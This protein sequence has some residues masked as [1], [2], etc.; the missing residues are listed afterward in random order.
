MVSLMRVSRQRVGTLD[1]K[2]AGN[3]DKKREGCAKTT[4]TYPTNVQRDKKIVRK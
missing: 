2:K 4:Q 3:A 1:E